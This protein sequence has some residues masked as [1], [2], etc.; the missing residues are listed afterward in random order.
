MNKLQ[1]L[2]DVNQ[3]GLE[4]KVG[5]GG[6]IFS[7]DDEVVLFDLVVINTVDTGPLCLC[8]VLPHLVINF[9]HMVGLLHAWD[10]FYGD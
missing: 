10:V 8:D 3:Q 2:E 6:S 5:D 1:R 7:H 4:G 9:D